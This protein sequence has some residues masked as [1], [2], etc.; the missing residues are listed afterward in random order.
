MTVECDTMK[1]RGFE[2]EDQ[3]TPMACKLSES[4]VALLFPSGP[5]L[6]KALTDEPRRKCKNRRVDTWGRN[7]EVAYAK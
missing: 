1:N 5:K 7:E 2:E 3:E 4:F 6:M